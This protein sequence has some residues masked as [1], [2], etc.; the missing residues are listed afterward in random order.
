MDLRLVEHGATV[1]PDVLS[2][3]AIVADSEFGGRTMDVVLTI[4]GTRL[5][6]RMPAGERGSWIRSLNAGE[7]LTAYFSPSDL[8]FFDDDGARI[9]KTVGARNTPSVVGV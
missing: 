5:H 8:T 2:F 9:P 6:S 3:T 1:P 4:G 7:Q